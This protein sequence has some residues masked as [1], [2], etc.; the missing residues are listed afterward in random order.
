MSISVIISLLS[1]IIAATALW[2]VNEIANRV[3]QQSK[4]LVNDHVIRLTQLANS[5]D[6][7]VARLKGKLNLVDSDL[8]DYRQEFRR[9]TQ[10]NK[11]ELEKL[12]MFCGQLEN[13][14][15]RSGTVKGKVR[16]T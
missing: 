3:I 1:L 8:Q 6:D 15:S 14:W 11:V 13:C 2:V 9:A 10:A 7:T 5:H 12:R 16:L 4:E